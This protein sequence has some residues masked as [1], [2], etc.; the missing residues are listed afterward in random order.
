VSENGK[1]NRRGTGAPSLGAP[2]ARGAARRTWVMTRSAE[3]VAAG[4]VGTSA[5]GEL[6]SGGYAIGASPSQSVRSS[7]GL[8]PGQV[9]GS[10]RA[11]GCPHVEIR[12]K[13][14]EGGKQRATDQD[15]SVCFRF[16][17]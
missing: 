17:P 4:E 5:R 16:G 2:C 3:A 9:R 1:G 6:E 12:K 13:V 15:G 8:P 14:R 7:V 10:D 11:K